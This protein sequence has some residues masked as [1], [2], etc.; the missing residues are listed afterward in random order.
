MSVLPAYCSLSAQRTSHAHSFR[1]PVGDIARLAADVVDPHQTVGDTLTSPTP[2]PLRLQC[3]ERYRER[4]PGVL[5]RR[6]ASRI[7]IP[8]PAFQCE[9]AASS[10]D[11]HHAEALAF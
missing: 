1:S 10:V 4:P 6:G 8:W 3:V 2:N 9:L 11:T 5:L 7:D